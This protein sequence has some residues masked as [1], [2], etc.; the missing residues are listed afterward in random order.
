MASPGSSNAVIVS[1]DVNVFVADLLSR[2]RNRPETLPSR[3]VRA[4]REGRF[5]DIPLQ[6]MLSQEML[7][8]LERV[9]VRLDVEPDEASDFVESVAEIMRSGPAPTEPYL[10]V[11]GRDQLTAKDREDSGVLASAILIRADLLVT[12]NLDDFRTK[13]SEIVPTRSVPTRD[14]GTRDL[15]AILFERA[16]GVALVIGHP[17]DVA[18]WL[19]AG[20]RP[21]PETIRQ[22]YRTSATRRP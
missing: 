21:T 8:T 1:L 13:D 4:V 17:L 14:G 7:G 3:L 15:Y 11:A 9:L 20:L 12:D 6:L 16:D 18:D 22:T 19:A 2:R 5:G 10:L